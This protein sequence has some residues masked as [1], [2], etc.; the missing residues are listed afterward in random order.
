[1]GGVWVFNT[2]THT[3]PRVMSGYYQVIVRLSDCL[4]GAGYHAWTITALW[5]YTRLVWTLL[6]R[7]KGLV[8][9]GGNGGMEKCMSTPA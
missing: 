5:L 9:P 2:N 4:Q 6:S 3:R 7:L 8:G 1:M